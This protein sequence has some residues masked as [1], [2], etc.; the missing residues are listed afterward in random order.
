MGTTRNASSK[1]LEFLASA[2]AAGGGNLVF[3]PLLEDFDWGNFASIFSGAE[4]AWGLMVDSR[5]R[6]KKQS[7]ATTA[8][9]L[10]LM[11]LLWW[12]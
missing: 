10:L 8:A 6:K 5:R 9:H 1:E 3:L 2:A 12:I 7:K 11:I 4:V